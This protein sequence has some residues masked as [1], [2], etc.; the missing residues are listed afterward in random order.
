MNGLFGPLFPCKSKDVHASH[1]A[2]KNHFF[3]AVVIGQR[4]HFRSSE[5]QAVKS[6]LLD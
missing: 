6:H 1:Q 2:P 5:N 4:F 3:K